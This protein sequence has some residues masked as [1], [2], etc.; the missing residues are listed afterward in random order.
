MSLTLATANR[1][2]GQLRHD[3]RTVALILLLPCLIVGLVAW[4]FDGTPVLDQFGPVLVGFF[5]LF[6][7]FLVT[8]VATQRERSSGTLERLMTTPLRKGDLVAGYA[9]AF[10]GLAVVQAFVVVGFALA[11]G[12]DVAGSL[13]LVVLVALLDAVLGCT[14]GLAASAVARTEFQAVQMMPLVIIPQI[15]TCGV[16]MPRDQMPQVLEWISRVLPLTYAV[17]ALQQLAAGADWAQVR[18][19]IGV[20]VLWIVGAV[21]LGVLTLRRRTE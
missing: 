14:L 4:M 21:V 5:P 20:I 9:L 2:L 3:H 11:V 1:V 13:G 15:I 8:S 12:M 17:E 19:A 10:G 18:G 7:M 6:V 16:L